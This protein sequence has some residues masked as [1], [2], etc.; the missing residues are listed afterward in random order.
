MPRFRIH[1]MKEAP[2]QHFRWAPHVSGA[3]QVKPKDYESDTEVHALHEYEAWANLQ[4]QSQPLQIGDLLENESG[5]LKICKYV[6]WETALWLVADLAAA[7][8]MA[9][10]EK[11]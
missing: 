11:A 10:P 6:G 5:E 2:R 7:S 1:R 3:V 9:Q 8:P 4:E